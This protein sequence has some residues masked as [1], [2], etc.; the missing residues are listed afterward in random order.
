VAE[1]ADLLFHLYVLLAVAGVDI[2]EVERE[3]ENR[4]SR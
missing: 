1:A 2:A 3:L 4:S